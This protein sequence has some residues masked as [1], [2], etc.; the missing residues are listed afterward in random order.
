M[1]PATPESV[2]GDFNNTHFD[3]AGTRTRF[4]QENGQ[5][6]VQTDGPD[7]GIDTFRVDYTFGHY[8]LQQ[9]LIELPGGRLQAFGIAWDSR[10]KAKVVNA[11]SIST[12]IRPSAQAIRFIGPGATRTG[13]SCAPS[14]TPRR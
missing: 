6:F 12:P 11:G 8:P 7:G 2:L 4:S 5:F 9:Y 10:S 13:T 14:A 1:Q 3:Y